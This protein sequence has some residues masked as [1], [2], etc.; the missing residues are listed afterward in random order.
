VAV[1]RL[2]RAAYGS[3]RYDTAAELAAMVET[4]LTGW[5]Q[6]KLALRSGDRE[7]AARSYS[8]LVAAAAREG[9]A[10]DAGSLPPELLGRVSAEAGVLSLAR[11]E[12]VEALAHLLR[13]TSAQAGSDSIGGDYSGDVAYVAERIL[14]IDE[15]RQFVDREV[16]PPSRAD[17][18]EA[19]ETNASLP[20]LSLRALLGRRL[21][22]AGQTTEALTY[23]DD[24]YVR[25]VA[26]EYEKHLARSR[27]RLRGAVAR[28]EALYSAAAIARFDGMEILGYELAP[29]FAIWSGSWQAGEEQEP[30][31]D[32]YTSA[33]ELA[34]L[35]RS[36]P[37]ALPRFHYTST[38]VEHAMRAADLLP[39]ST[40]AFAAVLCQA[41][42][43]A[44][45]RDPEVA[46]AVYR[47]YV[48]EGAY[49]PWAKRFGKRCPAPDF[50]SAKR[51]V[52]R[53]RLRPLRFVGPLDGLVLLGL[54]LLGA[55]VLQ[56][57][58]L[59]ARR[60]PSTP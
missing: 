18:E 5:I 8:R 47:R 2:A 13:A 56:A 20:A 25:E 26:E 10:R 17:V 53:A 43:W 12:Y 54:A 7:L 23:F 3:G 22:R 48:A 44:L 41:C 15:L 29:D 21:M 36:D 33:D 14:T 11:G 4:P 46:A 49:V 45:N 37:R 9:A 57:R 40:Q 32:D 34:R 27:S 50:A 31:P 39:R 42:G 60:R 58:R 1:E 28:A 59:R 24:E 6:A 35:A 38:A 55:A 19:L 30:I 52:W 51:A 16:P